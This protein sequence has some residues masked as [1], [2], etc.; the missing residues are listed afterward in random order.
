[1]IAESYYFAKF[2]WARAQ[3]VSLYVYDPCV[4]I[5]TSMPIGLSNMV[6]VCNQ[7]LERFIS[8]SS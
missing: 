7:R 8:A 4:E 1:V 5:C 6:G 2:T 3:V